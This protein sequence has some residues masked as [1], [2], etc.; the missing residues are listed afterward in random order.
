M[1][2]SLRMVIVVALAGLLMACGDDGTTTVAPHSPLLDLADTGPGWRLGPD[3]NDAD[4]ADSTQL[5]CDDMALN[6]TIN[7]RLTPVAGIQFEPTDGSSRHLIEFLITG[8][9]QRLEADLQAYFEAMNDCA[10]A[11]PVTTG[12]GTLTVKAFGI[13]PL[14]DQ[15]AAYAMTA[16]LSPEATWHVRTAT[17]RVGSLAARVALTEILTEPDTQPTIADDDFVRLVEVAVAELDR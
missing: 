17:V 10:A 15:R 14:G 2:H 16:V 13:P 6:P 4:F 8:D 12:A 7:A 5:P 11:T 9:T 3:V 1:M